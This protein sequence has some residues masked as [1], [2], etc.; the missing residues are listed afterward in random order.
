MGQVGEAPVQEERRE[1]SETNAF[2]RSLYDV[3]VVVTV[4]VGQKTI[5]VAELLKL[6]EDTVI[7]FSSH[8]EDPV[9]L[10][11]N[12]KVIARGELIEDDDGGLAVKITQVESQVDD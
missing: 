6:S 2:K 1:K 7:P 9:D 8:I 11:V 10:T 3:P 4:S 12:N 5:S